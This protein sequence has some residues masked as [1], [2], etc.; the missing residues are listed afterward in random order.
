MTAGRCVDGDPPRRRTARMRA[1]RSGADRHVP[2]VDRGAAG[3]G[4]DG[5][6]GGGRAIVG[7]RRWSGT[8]PAPAAVSGPRRRVHL[9]AASHLNPDEG[10]VESTHL[11]RDMRSEKG[12]CSR[13]RP[14]RAPRAGAWS[15][16]CA[17]TKSC[18]RDRALDPPARLG[19]ARRIRNRSMALVAVTGGHLAHDRHVTRHRG[20]RP[21]PGSHA[22]TGV[23]GRH[24]DRTPSPGSHAV[25]RIARRH[26]HQTGSGSA[27]C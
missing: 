15:R 17:S 27:G 8:R 1:V 11:G 16:P 26:P 18:A 4:G 21:S 6:R 7:L 9:T 12:R 22:V 25:T 24:P 23:E 3:A 14:G 2:P 20:R 19:P 5:A 13:R 10:C